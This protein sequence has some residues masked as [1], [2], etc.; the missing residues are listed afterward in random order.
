MTSLP[1][2]RVE[3]AFTPK[4][5]SQNETIL[6]PSTLNIVL[7]VRDGAPVPDVPVLRTKKLVIQNLYYLVSNSTYLRNTDRLREIGK[8]ANITMTNYGSDHDYLSFLFSFYYRSSYVAVI[9]VAT[10]EDRASVS[11]MINSWLEDAAERFSSDTQEQ[12]VSGELPLSP[13]GLQSCSFLFTTNVALRRVLAYS[14][15]TTASPTLFSVLPAYAALNSSW[16]SIRL[17]TGDRVILTE[18]QL[19]LGS[20]A[21]E[22][23]PALQ[24]T[25]NSSITVFLR[26]YQRHYLEKQLAMVVRQSVLPEQVVILQNR[27]LTQFAYDSL[28]AT[29]AFKTR[30]FYI[31]NVNWNAFFHLSYLVS[32]VMPT[33]LSFTFDDDQLLSDPETNA[34]AVQALIARPAIYSLRAWCW[35]KQYLSK[36]KVPQCGEQCKKA[37]DLVVN[38]FF[39]FSA[40]GRFMWRYDI[41]MYFCC[42]EMSY[43][44]SASIECG[45][46]WY[47]L[48]IQY[49]SFQHDQQSRDRDDYTQRIMKMVNWTVVD[50]YPMIYY[51]RAGYKTEYAYD[52]RYRVVKRDVFP[53]WRVCLAFSVLRSKCADPLCVSMQSR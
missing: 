32:A 47:T 29:Y 8:H 48:P 16:T 53:I 21:L 1:V 35:C 13:M 9:N 25:R 37:A 24:A 44:L 5:T 43:L 20:I 4:V 50:H 2:D 28:A 14:S 10:T 26:L 6:A 15:L 30:V 17:P 39:T 41:P 42:E 7:R 51:T 12:V 52:E 22:K 46:R 3:E 19:L 40:M 49:S 27:N 33:P 45:V 31:W 18:E 23:C 34:R 11:E 36:D 38:P